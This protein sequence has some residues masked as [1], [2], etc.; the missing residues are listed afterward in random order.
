MLD[1][2][3]CGNDAKCAGKTGKHK[4]QKGIEYH[5]LK[6]KRTRETLRNCKTHWK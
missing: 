2:K 6:Q 3:V 1:G 5:G 4:L